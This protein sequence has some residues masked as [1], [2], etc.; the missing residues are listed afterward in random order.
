M[1]EKTIN[2]FP[3]WVIEMQGPSYMAT[4]RLGGYEFYWTD[5]IHDAIRFFY[6]EQA[7]L[8]MMTIRQLRGDLFPSCLTRVPCAVEH[9]WFK[10]GEGGDGTKTL[11]GI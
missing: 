3:F 4:R 7:D 6:R 8:V 9:S 11:H 5:N 1:K 10:E 2:H